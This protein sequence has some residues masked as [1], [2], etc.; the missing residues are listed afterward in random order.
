MQ[1]H[2]WVYNLVAMEVHYLQLLAEFQSL[3]YQ[4]QYTTLAIFSTKFLQRCFYGE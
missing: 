4:W 3:S 2:H 1:T